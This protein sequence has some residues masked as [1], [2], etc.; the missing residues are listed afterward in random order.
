MIPY[1]IRRAR[2]QLQDAARLQRLEAATLGD[3]DLSAEEMCATLARPEQ[4]VFFAELDDALVGFCATFET[5]IPEGRRLEL[6]MLGVAEAHRG[7][8]IAQALVR[9]AMQEASLRGIRSFR[10]VVAT[11]NAASVS[12]FAR[13]GLSYGPRPR[14]MLAYALR[15]H[16]PLPYLPE[17][18]R[19]EA[20]PAAG[21]ATQGWPKALAEYSGLP[22]YELICLRDAAGQPVAC[23]VFLRVH[24]LAYE[25]LWIEAYWARHERAW[26]AL[27]RAA[28]EEAKA[29]QLDEVGLLFEGSIESPLLWAWVEEGYQRRGAYWIY[30]QN[31]P[32]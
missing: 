9:C 13:C 17:G 29:A 18:W 4:A 21:T 2:P 30:T 26:R 3:S 22:E 5:A 32:Q 31:E 7:R 14:Q 19:R 24:T 28:V 27:A 6:D 12:V 1:K 23:G 11:D 15:G 25:G 8:G 20:A 10:A 16:A